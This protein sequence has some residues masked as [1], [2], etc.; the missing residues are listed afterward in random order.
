MDHLSENVKILIL[1]VLQGI[2][3]FLPISSSGHLVVV[4]ELLGKFGEGAELNIVLHFGTLLSILVFY[5]RRIL[6]LLTKDQRAIGLLVV[7]SIPAAVVG[8]VV[9]LKFEWILE[10]TLLVGLMFPITGLLLLGLAK[11]RDSAGEE[12]TEISLSKA[13]AIGM[14]QAFAILPGIS[15]SGATIAT[16]VMLGLR[17]EAA[18][19]FSFL[20]AIPVIGGAMLLQIVK[21]KGF[22]MPIEQA[23]L[24]I[25]VSFVVGLV[26][27]ALLVRLLSA[28]KLHWFAFWLIPLGFTVV[29][30]Q[31]MK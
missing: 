14:A 25:G 26:S 21:T 11:T 3:E 4:E 19:T 7:G 2:A 16:G 20:L 1:S 31:L 29:A 30:W 22:Y 28:G 9:K 6:G 5:W 23:L 18:A 17:R 15:R 12:F 10:S 8:L 24:G 13:F 27:L